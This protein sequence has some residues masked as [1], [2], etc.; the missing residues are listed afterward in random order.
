MTVPARFRSTPST[1]FA[2]GSTTKAFT[3]ATIGALVDDGLAE[4]QRPL[5]DYLPTCGCRKTS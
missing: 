4:W 1:L 2:I 3:A 5:R